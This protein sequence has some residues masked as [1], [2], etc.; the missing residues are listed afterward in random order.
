M[1][2]FNTS[3]FDYI[4]E[5]FPKYLNDHMDDILKCEYLIPDT[6][7]DAMKKGFCKVKLLSTTARWQGI[8]YKEDK[9]LVVDEISGLIN[10][11]VYPAKLWD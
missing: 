10:E 8:T 3:I 6:V 2:G 5:N 11:G 1:L 4:E 7:F 9:Q